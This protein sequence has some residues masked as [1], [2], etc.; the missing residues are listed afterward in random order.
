MSI[1]NALVPHVATVCAIAVLYAGGAAHADPVIITPS[2]YTLYSNQYQG[3]ISQAFTGPDHISAARVNVGLQQVE[4]QASAFA[5]QHLDA[6]ALSVQTPILP[7]GDAF[8]ALA[9]GINDIGNTTHAF[10][11]GAFYGRSYYMVVA[12]SPVSLDNASFPL[13]K[14]T[15][16]AGLGGGSIHGLFGSLSSQ[17]PLNLRGTVEYDS[18]EFNER[19]ACPVAK[20]AQLEY[21][22][23]A[24][25]NFVGLE[26]HTPASF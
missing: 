7:E 9:V 16:T 23:M 13:R 1:R 6:V 11:R 17:F 21:S 5:N 4:L 12:K 10:G 20:Y 25:E 15:F 19:L 14:L 24:G 18:R 2:A 26:L 22:Y 8:P 3:E